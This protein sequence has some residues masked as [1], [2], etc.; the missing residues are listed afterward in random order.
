MNAVILKLQ[1]LSERHLLF[2]DFDEQPLLGLWTLL[3]PYV[4]S[5]FFMVIKTVLEDMP[6]RNKKKGKVP[7]G[8]RTD[9]LLEMIGTPEYAK[10]CKGMQIGTPANTG[11]SCQHLQRLECH[12]CYSELWFVKEPQDKLLN[13]SAGLNICWW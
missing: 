8:C 9:S 4:V 3:N 7:M 10:D 6:T 11:I 1:E 12:K 13:Y 5:D 2:I